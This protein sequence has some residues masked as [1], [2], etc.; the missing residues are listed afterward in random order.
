[1]CLPDL[2]AEGLPIVKLESEG[3]CLEFTS[4][5]VERLESFALYGVSLGFRKLITCGRV[6]K[7]GRG[8]CLIAVCERE[9]GLGGLESVIAA[10]GVVD[11]LALGT[12]S[13]C[14]APFHADLVSFLWPYSKR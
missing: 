3:D 4:R 2:E 11:C 8:A 13:G 5:E 14:V 1:M 12:G 7:R 6:G 9:A 10:E